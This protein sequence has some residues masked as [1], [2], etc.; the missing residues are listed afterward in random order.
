MTDDDAR[1]WLLATFGARAVDRLGRFVSLLLAEAG[2]QSLVARSTFGSIWSRHIV[3]SAQ[4]ITLA[5]PEGRWLDIGSGG[6][7]PGIVVAILREAP[8]VM[9]EPRRKR[10]EFLRAASDELALANV[11]V[12]QDKVQ[13][14]ADKAAVISAR[15]VAPPDEIFAWTTASVSLGTTY[16]LPRGENVAAD[17]AIAQRAWHGTFHVEQS[18]T[19]LAAGIVVARDVRPR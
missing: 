18:L 10:V 5:P 16:L 4:L 3:D 11:I 6:G 17:L 13:K 2:Q 19:D 9:V 7:L 8:L 1:D 12:V 15:A 14:V